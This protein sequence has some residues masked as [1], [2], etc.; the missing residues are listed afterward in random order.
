[1]KGEENII[2][3]S[4]GISAILMRILSLHLEKEETLNM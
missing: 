3:I 4:L 1:M 2:E